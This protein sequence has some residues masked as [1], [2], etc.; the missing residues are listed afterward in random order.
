MSEQRTLVTQTQV[1]ALN[2]IIAQIGQN[3]NTHVNDS[4]TRAHG[5]NAA[6]TTYFDTAGDTVGNVVIWFDFGTPPNVTRLYV[7]AILTTLG[8]ARTDNGVTV[9][10]QTP[11]GSSISPGIPLTEFPLATVFT[12]DTANS[13]NIY[14]D[15]LLAHIGGIMTDTGAL[16]VHGG[17]AFSTINSLDQLGHVVGRNLVQ[18]GINGTAFNL[19]ADSLSSGPP[20]PPRVQPFPQ[21][22]FQVNH[23][24]SGGF[25][26]LDIIT[27]GGSTL[28]G[29]PSGF[30][31]EYGIVVTPSVL[32]TGCTFKW[33]YNVGGSFTGHTIPNDTFTEIP[34]VGHPNTN[35]QVFVNSFNGAIFFMSGWVGGDTTDYVQV[36]LTVSDTAASTTK[37]VNG[38]DL[39]IT[40]SV[41]NHTRCCWFASQANIT[42]RLSTDEW[43]VM[44]MIEQ[45]LFKLNRRSVTFYVKHGE[46]LVKKMIAGGV[47]QSWFEEFID[48]AVKLAIEDRLADAGEYYMRTVL[49]MSEK[50]WPD[51]KHPGLKALKSAME[52][53]SV[54]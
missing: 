12:E 50:Y 22:F 11:T 9:T 6:F 45:A 4:L 39:I 20:Q 18:I 52:T 54:S 48:R 14:N 34:F 46:E 40:F 26:F 43:R 29:T 35:F 10:A 36:R 47:E 49:E 25:G 38:A 2:A 5:L 44:G 42:R 24:W 32:P 27:G 19:I 28:L 37:A 3:L 23:G 15:L 8:P 31:N 30:S 16:Q 7:P 17:A 1:D 41:V 13:L 53:L 51:C 33:E 21:T